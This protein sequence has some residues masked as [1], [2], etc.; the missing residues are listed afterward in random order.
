MHTRD[1]KCLIT[2]V[3]SIR[4]VKKRVALVINNF[5]LVRE[6][7]PFRELILRVHLT[8]ENE[9]EGIEKEKPRGESLFCV[10]SLSGSFFVIVWHMVHRIIMVL[11]RRGK[12][13]NKGEMTSVTVET[14]AKTSETKTHPWFSPSHLFFERLFSEQYREFG[15]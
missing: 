3:L 7:G 11:R 4:T 14:H 12:K 6:L 13:S 10:S 9:S 5:I 15:F 1:S 8:E 2:S